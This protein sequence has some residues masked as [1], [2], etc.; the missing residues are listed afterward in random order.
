MRPVRVRY[1]PSPTG[2]PH[3]GNLRT[4]V[5]DWLTARKYGGVF[6][7]RLEDTDRDPTRYKPEYIAE[8]EES[9]R[10]LGITPD[11][12]WVSGGPYGPYVQSE[13]LG[14]YQ[15]AACTL[16]ERGAAYP[17][18]CT[19]ERLSRLREE[20]KTAGGATG[21][22]RLC[23]GMDAAEAQRRIAEGQP[24]TVRLAVPLE[25]VTRYEDVVYGAVEV[26]NRVLDDQILLKSNGWPTYHLAVVVDDHL[27]E[28]THVIRGEDWMPSTPKQ[29]LIYQAMGWEQPVWVHIPLTLGSDRKK[30][31]KRHGATRFVD[32]MQAGYLPEAM[33]NF[34][35][36]LG[37]SAGEENREILSVEEVVQRF[38]LE[39][40]SRT[41]AIFDYDKLRWMNGEYIRQCDLHRLAEL[42]LPFLQRAGLIPSP[43]R[44]EDRSKLMRVLPLLRERM[45]LL[46]DVVEK[47]RPFL[48]EPETPDPT[49]QR[50]WLAG[51]E[52]RRRLDRAIEHLSKVEPDWEAPAL[53]EAV[54]RVAEELGINRAPVIHTLRV[55]ATGTTAGPGLFETLE[56]LGRDTVLRRLQR[57]KEWLVDE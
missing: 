54:N 24:Y 23:R 10:W 55:A 28:I 4:A 25:G 46:G 52:A 49:G 53:E 12:W 7:A 47:A 9:L 26:E 35:V 41:P 14:L 20:Q 57:A 29:V 18:F 17:C 40:I 36:L 19:E 42:C 15:D 5:F 56:V 38:R 34:L 27:M 1:A 21:Y 39:D 50:K 48:Q 45:H 6:V 31:S 44:P 22:D 30:L 51:P 3:V 11:E 13:R 16:I 8:I 37:W 43:A 2:S 32:F 33:F